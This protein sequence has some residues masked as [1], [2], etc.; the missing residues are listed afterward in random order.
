MFVIERES[1]MARGYSANRDC[2]LFVV[3]FPLDIR[4]LFGV[5]DAQEEQMGDWATPMVL[6]TRRGATVTSVQSGAKVPED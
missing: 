1:E 3:Y 4:I 5:L 6:E 2:C